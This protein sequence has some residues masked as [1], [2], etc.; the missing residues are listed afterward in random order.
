[1]PGCVYHVSDVNV[2]LGRQR[3]GGS[4]DQ[5]NLFFTHI[6]LLLCNEWLVFLL[7]NVWNSST[8]LHNVKAIKL[9]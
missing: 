1:M 5:I 3:E 9:G 2:Y 8:V 6:F 7:A 4:P